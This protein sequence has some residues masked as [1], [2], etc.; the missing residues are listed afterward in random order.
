M[1]QN[2][3]GNIP[4]GL[5]TP[6]NVR[7]AD[8]PGVKQQKQARKAYGGGPDVFAYKG[9]GKGVG[10]GKGFGGPVMPFGGEGGFG[11][12]QH[13]STGGDESNLYIKGL[14]PIADDLYLYKLFAPYGAVQSVRV[15]EKDGQCSGIGFAKFTSKDE[16]QRAIHNLSGY[17]LQDGSVIYISVK[18]P[19]NRER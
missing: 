6:I 15:I 12:R 3:N 18:T 7:Y 9:K 5:T 1:V 16:A 2:L 11:G 14:P 19:G 13:F 17:P 10:K 4:Q 8:N